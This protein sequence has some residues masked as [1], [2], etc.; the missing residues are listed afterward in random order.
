MNFINVLND[1]HKVLLSYK[2]LIRVKCEILHN[3]P[4]D[5]NKSVIT[6]YQDTIVEKSALGKILMSTKRKSLQVVRQILAAVIIS[7]LRLPAPVDRRSAR[8]IPPAPE[9]AA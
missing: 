3:Q 7:H 6:V 8:W 5:K 9:H 2:K 1:R 4:D